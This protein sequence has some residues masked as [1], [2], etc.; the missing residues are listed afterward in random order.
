M[1]CLQVLLAVIFLPLA[2]IDRGCVMCNHR[3]Y[4][5]ALWLASR[6]DWSFDYIK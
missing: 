3:V 5:D 6:G 4:P 2:V 1:S